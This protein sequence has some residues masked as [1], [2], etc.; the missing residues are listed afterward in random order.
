MSHEGKR[1]PELMARAQAQGRIIHRITKASVA[2]VSTGRVVE[3]RV[4]EVMEER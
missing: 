2:A 3:D 1:V 4:Q